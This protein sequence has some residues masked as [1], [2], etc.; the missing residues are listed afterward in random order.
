MELRNEEIPEELDWVTERN[1]C[2]LR[3]AF[4]KL[5]EGIA[6][7]VE[8]Y[9]AQLNFGGETN[10]AYEPNWMITVSR[11]KFTH[12][13]AVFMMRNDHIEL[14]HEGLEDVQSAKVFPMLTEGGRCKFRVTKGQSE[15]VLLSWQLRRR[16]LEPVFF[17]G[18]DRR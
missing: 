4:E 5:Q 17:G 9:K 1:K 16:A 6:R 2:E 10:H 7:D 14:K 12:R 18:E 11:R 3:A 8:Q 15:E 13:A